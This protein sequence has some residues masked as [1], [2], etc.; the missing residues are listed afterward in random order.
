MYLAAGVVGQH[1]AIRRQPS[2][3]GERGVDRLHPSSIH[4][5]RFAV[6]IQILQIVADGLFRVAPRAIHHR[7][8]CFLHRTDI[9]LPLLRVVRDLPAGRLQFRLG[10]LDLRGKAHALGGEHRFAFLLQ[11]PAQLG[12]EGGLLLDAIPLVAQFLAQL[13]RLAV[14]LLHQLG[15][16]LVFRVARET[17]VGLRVLFAQLRQLDRRAGEDILHAVNIGI[18]Q[19]V[20][21]VR[22]LHGVPGVVGRHAL[23]IGVASRAAVAEARQRVGRGQLFAGQHVSRRRHRAQRQRLDEQHRHQYR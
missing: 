5:G 12:D 22:H 20:Q 14:H 17:R 21:P 7:G 2:H 8:Q 11:L 13:L 3:A 16:A 4:D 9:R 1:A 15:H 6:G 23:V 19:F 18:Q 10:G